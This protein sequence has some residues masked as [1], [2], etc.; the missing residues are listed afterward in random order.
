MT[1]PPAAAVRHVISQLTSWRT[2]SAPL[3]TLLEQLRALLHDLSDQQYTQRPAGPV[4]SSVGAH[5]RHCLDHVRALARA[6][7]TGTIDYDT[8]ERN[9]A[10]ESDREAAS[11][12]IMA[13]MRSLAALPDAWAGCSLEMSVLLSADEAPVRVSTTI[14][15]EL[16]FVLNHTIHHNAIIGIAVRALGGRLPE[17]FGYAPST[18]RQPSEVA[19]TRLEA[20]AIAREYEWKEPCP[21]GREAACAQ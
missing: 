11:G 8:R 16:A 1:N 13:L 6:I 15:R 21:S 4:E 10:V 17:R 20:R 2:L 14:G 12:E 18:L 19:Q 9:T 3:I 5:V 7:E